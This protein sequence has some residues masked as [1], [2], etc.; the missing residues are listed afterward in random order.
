MV[1]LT[2]NVR[3]QEGRDDPS[4]LDL[5]TCVKAATVEMAVC[6]LKARESVPPFWL[7]ITEQR[8]EPAPIATNS[9]L[10]VVITRP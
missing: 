5:P 1:P 4:C 10:P 8:T 7:A 2:L 6:G 9:A 3:Y